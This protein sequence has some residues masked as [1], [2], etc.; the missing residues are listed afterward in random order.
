MLKFT[1]GSS[2]PLDY[3]KFDGVVAGYHLSLWG[4]PS[5]FDIPDKIYRGQFLYGHRNQKPDPS[6][7]CETIAEW[8]TRRVSLYPVISEWVLINEFTDDLGVP[9]PNYKI[10]NLKRYFEAAHLANPEAKL[11]VGEFKPHLLKKWESVSNICLELKASG[12]PV[13][14]GVQTHMKTYNAPVV[15]AQL[16]ELIGMFNSI[17]IHFIEASLWYQSEVDKLL[18]PG[19]WKELEAIANNHKVKSFC[20]WWLTEEDSHVGR[21]MPTFESLNLFTQGR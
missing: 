3:S 6:S 8:V 10:D 11:I 21:R 14:M 15:L 4:Q 9:Y 5:V 13:E 16:P 2:L 20:N 18:C 12:F 17:Q 7:G 1:C 19:F